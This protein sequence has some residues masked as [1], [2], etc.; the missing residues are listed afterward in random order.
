MVGHILHCAACKHVSWLLTSPVLQS[1]L[2]SAMPA[3]AQP[4]SSAPAAAAGPEINNLFEAAKCVLS[5]TLPM[6]ASAAL[7]RCLHLLQGPVHDVLHT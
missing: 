6:T 1:K 3:D 2:M 4:A 5:H 7:Q